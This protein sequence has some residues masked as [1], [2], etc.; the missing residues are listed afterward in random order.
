MTGRREGRQRSP[1]PFC[2]SETARV[3]AGVA[4]VRGGGQQ[5]RPRK[6]GRVP[7]A[8]KAIWYYAGTPVRCRAFTFVVLA[9]LVMLILPMKAGR[10]PLAVHTLIRHTCTF[11]YTFVFQSFTLV[12]PALRIRPWSQVSSLLAPPPATFLHV[13]CAD[14]S[15]SQPIALSIFSQ[16]LPAYSRFRALR[17]CAAEFPSFFLRA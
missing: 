7:R 16:I 10:Y 3:A 5:S 2:C 17:D 12:F 9:L 13:C 4:P 11:I 8:A 14:N 1:L 6:Q 15:T